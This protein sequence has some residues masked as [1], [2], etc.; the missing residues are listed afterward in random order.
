MP[1]A[2]LAMSH[3]YFFFLAQRHIFSK[4][5]HMAAVLLVSPPAQI[6]R[7]GGNNCGL[8]YFWLRE[9]PY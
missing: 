3:L 5:L 9:D 1:F 2:T 8:G 4:E 7:Q 6:R